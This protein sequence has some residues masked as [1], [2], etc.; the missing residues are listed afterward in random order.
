[1]NDQEF[2]YGLRHSAA[3]MLAAA[4]LKL[5]PGTKLGTGPVIDNGFY[6]DVLLPQPITED[7]LPKIEAVMRE[8]IAGEHSFVRRPV[9]SAEAKTFFHDQPFKQELVD[10]FSVDGRALT[11]YESGPFTDLCEGNHADNTKQL[12][13][14]GFQL[15]KLAGAYWQADSTREQ[16][17]RIYG[18]LFSTPKELKQY[19]HQ[20]EE[21]KKRDHRKLGKELDLFTFS[22]LVGAGL[23][24]FT[25]RGT[26]IRRE[27]ENYIAELR[28]QR[29]FQRVWIPHMAKADLYK[30]SGHWDKFEDDLFHVHSKKTDATF[31][32][33]PM[34]CPHHTQI[35]ASQ[36]RSYKDLPIRYFETTT[37]YRDENTGQIQGLTR[38]RSLTQDDSH[39]FART[40]Q[41]QQ[42]AELAQDIITELYAKF[43]LELRPRFS[44]HDPA[45]MENYLGTEENWQQSETILQGVMESKG[46]QYVVGLGEAAFYG[47]KI[48][49]MAVDSLGREWQLATIQLDVNQPERFALSFTNS[50]GKEERPVMIHVAVMGS[51]ERFMGVIIEHFAGNFPTWLAP[52]QVKLLPISD[53]HIQFTQTIQEQLKARG[54]RVELDDASETVGNKI[55]KAVSEKTPYMVVVGDQEMKTGKL[56][57]R[58]RG[59]KETVEYSTAE[60]MAYVQ[61]QINTKALLI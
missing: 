10:K 18:V 13:S 9:S 53:Q 4:V 26:T 7:D 47:P 12:R 37:N 21:A 30:T 24:L 27:L 44:T 36:K 51:V 17:T 59:S 46:L 25:P 52:V 50:E 31:V 43:G 48:D 38:V 35:F 23:P 58:K 14:V 61:E 49:Y 42:E 5:Y 60:F 40:D 3:H 29:G 22:E 28:E 6:Y 55:R 2:L 16:M 32:M 8:I 19:F 15:T 34:N 54:V 39:V 45:K 33:K 20:L 11:L 57:V 41:I 1:M 56:S